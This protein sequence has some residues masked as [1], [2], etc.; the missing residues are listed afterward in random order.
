MGFVSQNIPYFPGTEAIE[1]NLAP[2]H[3]LRFARSAFRYDIRVSPRGWV[4]LLFPHTRDA[5]MFILAQRINRDNGDW[6]LGRTEV[7]LT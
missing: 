7:Y 6:V 5:R 2:I 3:L 4:L 1:I